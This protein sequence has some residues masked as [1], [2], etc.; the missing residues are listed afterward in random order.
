MLLKDFSVCC[1]HC[2]F[3]VSVCHFKIMFAPNITRVKGS[4]SM[5][6]LTSSFVE[7]FLYLKIIGRDISIH[8]VDVTAAV[9][10]PL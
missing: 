6:I 2:H 10:S 5:N 4:R 8:T 7:D 9:G 1:S 3:M